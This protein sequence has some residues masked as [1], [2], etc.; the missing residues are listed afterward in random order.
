MRT[1]IT[2]TV[3]AIAAV[4]LFSIGANSKPV[5]AAAEPI[6]LL[7]S[8]RD[9]GYL[10]PFKTTDFSLAVG[11]KDTVDL[12]PKPG[13][14][15]LSALKS[16]DEL[17]AEMKRLQAIKNPGPPDK[18]MLA[19]SKNGVV[20]VGLAGVPDNIAITVSVEGVSLV[21]APD[22]LRPYV[23]N[24]MK[25]T[26]RMISSAEAAFYARNE[27][28]GDFAYLSNPKMAYLDSRFAGDPNEV[29]L[30]N[31]SIRLLVQK[32]GQAFIALA[33]SDRYH[34]SCIVD[35]TGQIRLV[36]DFEAM[37]K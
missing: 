13:I 24:Q 26:L 31:F 14:V 23:E 1:N 27:R 11:A 25:A 7:F 36:G 30:P 35:S 33:R 6:F 15:Y 12:K 34:L 20:L 16:I 5:P 8:A 19:T 37:G 21:S 3:C 4:C 2:M 29:E 32:D 22:T 9:T 28:Y 17:P 10:E 18:F